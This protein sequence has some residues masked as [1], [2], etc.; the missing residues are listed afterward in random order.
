MPSTLNAINTY[1]DTKSQ[2]KKINMTSFRYRLRSSLQNLQ[3]LNL[4]EVRTQI[5]VNL[6]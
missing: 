6:R 1:L 4:S 5:Y 2:P 3:N